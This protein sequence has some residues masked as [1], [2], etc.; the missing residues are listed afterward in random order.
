MNSPPEKNARRLT[1]RA[2]F[3]SETRYRLPRISQATLLVWRQQ[4]ARLRSEHRRTGDL[5]HLGAFHRHCGG[6]AGGYV[7]RMCDARCDL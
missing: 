5:R 7:E 1:G 4:T 3:N 6:M 2:E